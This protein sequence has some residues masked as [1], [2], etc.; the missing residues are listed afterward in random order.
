[1]RD[2]STSMIDANLHIDHDNYRKLARHP[3][4]LR[5]APRPLGGWIGRRDERFGV[6]LWWQRRKPRTVRGLNHH[7]ASHRLGIAV[8]GSR[9]LIDSEPRDR[10]AAC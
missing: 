7:T 5:L 6:K 8:S 2:A 4:G 1:M 3:L 10:T 9:C